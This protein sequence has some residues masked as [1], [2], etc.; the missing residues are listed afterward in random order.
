MQGQKQSLRTQLET[1]KKTREAVR[2]SLRELKNNLKFT[3]G[4]VA[5]R[6]VKGEMEEWIGMQMLDCHVGGAGSD[7]GSWR[8][9]ANY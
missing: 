7:W 6:L 9:L 5:A 1:A 4:A 3:T 2:T 8:N